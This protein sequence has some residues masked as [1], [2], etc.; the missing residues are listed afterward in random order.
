[1]KIHVAYD[2]HGRILAASELGGDAPAQMPGTT[3]AELDVPKEF[4]RAQATDCLHLLHVNVGQ[5]KLFKV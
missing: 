5:R 4:E 2:Q 1:M 3:V